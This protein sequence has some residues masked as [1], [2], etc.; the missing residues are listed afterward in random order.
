[1]S[2]EGLTG[3]ASRGYVMKAAERSLTR[4]RT[5]YIDV[6]YLHTPDPAVSVEET[7]RALDDLIRQGKVRH[8]AASNMTPDLL[9]EAASIATSKR[10]NAFIA[11]QEQYSRGRYQ[12]CSGRGERSRR[13]LDADGEGAGRDRRPGRGRVKRSEP[14]PRF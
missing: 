11:T 12:R 2:G 8:A 13:D 3:G 6:L 1:M 10:L 4:L 14:A 7:L 9:S 5:D